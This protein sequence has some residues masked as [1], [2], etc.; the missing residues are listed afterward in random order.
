MPTNHI[1]IASIKGEKEMDLTAFC[2]VPIRS[3]IAFN[4]PLFYFAFFYNF[5]ELRDF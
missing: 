2:Y 3:S 5:F 1:C 4:L